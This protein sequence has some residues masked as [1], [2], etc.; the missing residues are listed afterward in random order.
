MGL[1]YQIYINGRSNDLATKRMMSFEIIDNIGLQLDSL[2]ISIN[3]ADKTIEIPTNNVE[4]E[5]AIGDDNKGYDNLYKMG[6][7][8]AQYIDANS[9][10]ISINAISQDLSKGRVRK[11]R[12]FKAKSLQDILQTLANELNLKLQ[13]DKTLALKQI[14]YY[15]QDNKTSTELIYELSEIFY[16][17]A[18]IK[19]GNL[20]FISKDNIK[21]LKIN[22]NNI[23]SIKQGN[24]NNKLYSGVMYETW[25][26]KEARLEAKKLGNE[27]YLLIKTAIDKSIVNNLLNAK[28]KEIKESVVINLL[29]QGNADYQSGF[30][31]EINST[32]K[33]DQFNGKY[34]IEKVIHKY[35]NAYVSEILA[36]KI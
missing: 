15:I 24:T 22:E 17:V 32:E 28:Y 9:S 2:S 29:V 20:I 36:V 18:N 30:M 26:T 27:T 3:N 19:D 25:N 7:F 1:T 12:V 31:F 8:I 10:T 11:N 5:L 23:L 34:R 35:S 13:I 6:K 16:A 33:Y 14:D 4:I 21:T